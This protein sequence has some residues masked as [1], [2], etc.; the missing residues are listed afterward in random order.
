MAA[1]STMRISDK[2]K[3]AGYSRPARVSGPLHLAPST[4][5]LSLD[6]LEGRT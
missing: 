4:P 3:H 6:Q 1:V 2:M 5:D